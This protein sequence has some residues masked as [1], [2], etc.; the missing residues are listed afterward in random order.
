MYIQGG[1]VEFVTPNT[2][3]SDRLQLARPTACVIAQQYASTVITLRAG[4]IGSS[5]QCFV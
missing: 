1:S 3:E 2:P 4:I 5:E